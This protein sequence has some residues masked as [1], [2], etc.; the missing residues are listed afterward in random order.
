MGFIDKGLQLWPRRHKEGG[1]DDA[2]CDILFSLLVIAPSRLG[3][4]KG[5]N[6]DVQLIYG[7]ILR[8]WVRYAQLIIGHGSFGTELQL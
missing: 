5:P 1:S 6:F 8:G 7:G 4:K 3:K 2:A